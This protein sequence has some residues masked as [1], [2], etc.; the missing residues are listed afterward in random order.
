MPSTQ[1]QLLRSLVLN[2]FAPLYSSGVRRYESESRD[3]AWWRMMW[4]VYATMDN[5]KPS[6][7]SV[8]E[9]KS[10][11]WINDIELPQE[12]YSRINN[13][14][15]LDPEGLVFVRASNAFPWL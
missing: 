14:R 9:N 15:I 3:F 4:F 6:P 2:P 5:S 12:A 7:R 11:V 8:F 10:V 13:Y 1:V